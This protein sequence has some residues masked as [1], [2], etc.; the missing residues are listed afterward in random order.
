MDA[1][2]LTQEIFVKVWQALKK[3]DLRYD[4]RSL[5]FTIAKNH[6]FDWLRKKKARSIKEFSLDENQD[7]IELIKD[8]LPLPSEA[9]DRHTT[10]NILSEALEQLA[11]PYRLVL[12]LYYH[13]QFSLPQIGEMLQE[14]V[15][16][17]KSRHRRG[18]LK[19]KGILSNRG[20]MAE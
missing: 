18:L 19:L 4:F 2:D 20:L 1:E 17:I 11:T 13:D 9:F 3:F 7:L 6:C 14:S 8:T 12:S 16:T 15:N 10:A 5:L